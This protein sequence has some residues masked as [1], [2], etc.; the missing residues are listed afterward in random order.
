MKLCHIKRNHPV[1]ITK[2]HAQCPPSAETQAFRHLR[3]TLIAVGH[4]GSETSLCRQSLALVL[5]T[6][7]KQ[8]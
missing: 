4:F 1:H 8:S 6:Q 7:D 2:C 3:K 5:T